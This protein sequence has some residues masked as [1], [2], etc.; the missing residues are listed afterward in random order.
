MVKFTSPTD[1]DYCKL[2]S[3]LKEIV[4]SMSDN[5]SKMSMEKRQREFYFSSRFV[6]AANG[7]SELEREK[8]EILAWL[9]A[10]VAS[11]YHHREARKRHREGTGKWFME[12]EIFQR[13]KY[14]SNS[15]CWTYGKC[16]CPYHQYFSFSKHIRKRDRAR[17]SSCA[18]LSVTAHAL[19]MLSHFSQVGIGGTCNEYSSDQHGRRCCLPLL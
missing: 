17:Q 10:P 16:E 19:D 6:H 5:L 12:H 3:I 18:W 15:L 9:R 1:D 11:S 4:S 13:W 2:V 8:R 7:S 14:G